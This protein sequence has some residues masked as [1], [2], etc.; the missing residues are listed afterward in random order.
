[1]IE[2]FRSISN[3]VEKRALE[4]RE[5]ILD[6]EVGQQP[7]GLYEKTPSIAK[8]IYNFSADIITPRHT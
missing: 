1:M 4:I 3:A 5:E 7:I 8:K 6:Q 2:I